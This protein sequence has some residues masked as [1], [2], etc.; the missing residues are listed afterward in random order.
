MH[1]RRRRRREPITRRDAH[2]GRRGVRGPL[3][4]LLALVAL[5]LGV[6]SAVGQNSRAVLADYEANGATITQCHDRE[7]YVAARASQDEPG[8]GDLAG[9]IDL[10][11][12]TPALL[13]TP[14]RPC[15]TSGAVSGGGDGGWGGRSLLVVIG[16]Q[17]LLLLVV[18]ALRR[19]Q[20][21]RG[22]RRLPRWAVASGAILI[23]EPAGLE[24]PSRCVTRRDRWRRKSPSRCTL[25]RHPSRT[26]A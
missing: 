23:L 13:G 16:L 2:G 15:P 22:L 7:D 17:V 12:D 6:P 9:A 18:A 20:L 25:Q 21:A 19:R 10:A 14:E 26:T 4:A 3:L 11:L 8:Y 24:S 1:H 5:L